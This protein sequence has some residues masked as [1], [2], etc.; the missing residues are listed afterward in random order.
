VLA[1]VLPAGT[2]G[3]PSVSEAAALALRGPLGPPPAPDPAHRY[4]LHARVGQLAFPS[5]HDHGLRVTGV[6]R[7]RLDGHQVVTVYYAGRGGRL[8]YAIVSSPALRRP[9]SAGRWVGGLHFQT[10]LIGGRTV[11]TWRQAGHTCVLA[12]RGATAAAMER[13]VAERG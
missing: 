3:G 13:L 12:A 11:I 8:A 7:D 9:P 6:R 4:L 1:L 2:P 5:W 10:L